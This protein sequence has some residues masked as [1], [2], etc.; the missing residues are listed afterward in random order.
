MSVKINKTLLVWCLGVLQP[1]SAKGLKR[2][3]QKMYPDASKLITI[4]EIENYLK[5]L[6]SV[7]FVALVH[8]SPHYYYSLT[9][10]G[11][12]LL[13]KDL[14]YNRDKARLFLLK[15]ACL[16][17]RNKSG[18]KAQNLAGASPALNDSQPQQKRRPIS[19]V[20]ASE[21]QTYW[22]SLSRQLFAGSEDD[23]PDLFLDLYTYPSWKTLKETN[24]I[25]YRSKN[26]FRT[27]IAAAIGISPKLIGYM[28]RKPS[29]HYRSFKI[30]K[31]GGGERNI[32]SPRVFLKTIQ[33]WIADY[34]LY[35]LKVHPRCFSYQKKKSIVQN[36]TLHE[37]KKYVANFDIENYF[38]SVSSDG[39]YNL[40]IRNK[41]ENN[42]SEVVSKIVTYRNKLPQGAPTSTIL[43]NAYLYD[44]DEELFGLTKKM[45]LTYSRYADDITVSGDNRDAIQKIILKTQDELKKY[46]L[47][48]NNKKTRIASMFS[49]QKV[50]GIVVNNKAK[51]P[52]KRLKTIR[53][54]F[55][56]AEKNPKSYK[57]RINELWGHIGYLN[58]F[59]SV[60]NNGILEKYR[61]T[62]NDLKKQ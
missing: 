54:I 57:E 62:I 4:D 46:G 59:P 27:Y 9:Q 5:K 10:R 49:Q 43:S 13:S 23:P 37:N 61:N 52:R 16:I 48:L 56:H 30:G 17:S 42:L 50:T 20:V 28:I 60:K 53:A 45:H 58:M 31:R 25:G 12:L 26:P 44:F 22:S 3:L 40:L 7:G 15:Q 34:L 11:N 55:H 2:F 14:R 32:D 19:L 38:G 1:I 24:I 36:A 39:I 6:L 47:S 8:K 21:N 18:V 35:N 29:D 33:Y 51:P 41:L